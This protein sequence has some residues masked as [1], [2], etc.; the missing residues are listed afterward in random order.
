MSNAIS[1]ALLLLGLATM[2]VVGWFLFGREKPPAPEAQR[3]PFMV[4]VTLG[5]ARRG[6]LAPEAA[7]TGE[8]ASGARTR[9][10]FEVAGRIT[11][12]AVEAGARVEAGSVLARLDRRD[13]EVA[14]AR[15]QAAEGLATRELERWLAGTRVE[16][17]KRL[18]A[19][20]A[21]RRAEAELARKQV[22]RG[23]EL[24]KAAVMSNNDYD[25]LVS[26]DE[27]AVARVAAAEQVLAEAEAGARQEEIAVQRAE[28][29]L[30]RAEVEIARRALEKC[31]LVAPFPA[32]VVE[33]IASVGDSVVAGTAVLEIVDRSR[34]ELQ[35]ELPSSIAARVPADARVVIGIED[36]ASFRL[37][38]RLDTLV[39]VADQQ[40]RAFRGIARL[41][42][43]ED[44]DERL[45][46][47]MF[48]RVRL[49]LAPLHDAILVPQDAVRVLPQ[50]S[51]V[52][53]AKAGEAPAGAPAGA[54]ALTAE[55]VPVRVVASHAGESAIESLAAPLAAGDKLVLIGADM[56]FPGAPLL[57]REPVASGAHQP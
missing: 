2:A 7:L 12:I 22:E 20:L 38:T 13:A 24:V 47:G 11:E 42:V 10:G 25:A 26:Q 41:A 8:V 28:V 53:R 37:E 15:A 52:V 17:R 39:P 5:E 57:P 40:S 44:R 50:G 55:W 36:D 35:V 14:L 18:A 27:A 51:V 29:A 43:D 4:A 49:T 32:A 31:E 1:N 48:V 19:E 21:A 46:P 54:A 9:I 3:P 16:E 34:R 33:R 30:R 56:A 45:K 6:E 23:R